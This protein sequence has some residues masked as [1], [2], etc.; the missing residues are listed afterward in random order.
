MGTAM[1]EAIILV[2]FPF[3]M[4]FAAMSDWVSMTITNRVSLVLV[5]TFAIVAPLTGMPMHDYALHFAVG[6]GVLVATFAIFAFGSMGGGDAKLLAATSLWMGW[7][8][9]LLDYL[10]GSAIL[11]GTLTLAILSFRTSA[12]AIFSTD[13]PF[14]KNFTSSADGVPYGIALGAG[15]LIAFSSSPLVVWAIDRL[16]SV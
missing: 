1:L 12:L 13:N 11:G 9:S 3:C 15:G 14:L 7:N 10:A 2:V 5:V 16:A 8:L 6:A 4:L